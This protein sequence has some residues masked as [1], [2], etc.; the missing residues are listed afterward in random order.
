MINPALNTSLLR[1]RLKLKNLQAESVL[2]AHHPHAVAQR[3]A[4]GGRPESW[5]AHAAKLLSA[6]AVAG[7]LMR[8]SPNSLPVT[9][10]LPESAHSSPVFSPDLHRQT[11]DFIKT[12]LPGSFGHLDPA[13]ESQVSDFLHQ[14]F[15]LHAYPELEGNRLNHSYGLIGAEQH[16]PRFPGDSVGEHGGFAAS[17]ITPGRGAWGYFASTRSDLTPDLV[18]QE[19]YYFAVQTLY[20][21]DWDARLP[22]L[23]DWYKY[24]KMVAKNPQNGKAVVGVVA[25]SGPSQFTGK[26]FGGSPEVMDYLEMQD[27][28]QR[29][30]VILYFVDDPQDQVPLGP[31]EYNLESPPLLV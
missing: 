3:E 29:G 4:A 24:R 15:G 17:G 28:R 8:A 11:A 12:R 9:A 19:K 27:G 20:L 5:R 18:A 26:H 2:R 6:G 23:R 16:L 30:A 25:D 7:S 21:P 1:Y 13:A 14:H 22:Y 10:A 31:L